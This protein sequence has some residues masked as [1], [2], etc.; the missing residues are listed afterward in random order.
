M[1]AL[2]V[3]IAL[4][5]I[6][7]ATAS[8]G[9]HAAATLRD[10]GGTAVGWAKLTEDGTGRLHLNVHV[11]GLTPGLHGIHIHTVGDCEPFADALGHL[12]P[13]ATQHGLDN[14]SGPHAGD[15]PNLRVNANGIGV[16]AVT[17]DR[18]ALAGSSILD[19]NGSALV[20]HANE[21][22]QVTNNDPA[23]G[24]GRSGARI[25]CGVIVPA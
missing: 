7:V 10:G 1:G 8:G 9:V 18:A 23:L 13:A 12:N 24:P 6:G 2:G 5:T 22:D 19:A 21:D 17:S 3:G 25:A 14:P 4:W 11:G 20:I 15:L 16:L